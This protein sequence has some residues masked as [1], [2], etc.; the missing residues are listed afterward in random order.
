MLIFLK[1][2]NLYHRDLKPENLLIYDINN[3][4]K[5]QIIDFGAAR[6]QRLN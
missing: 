6:K 3:N 5:L 2:N 1:D 4:P